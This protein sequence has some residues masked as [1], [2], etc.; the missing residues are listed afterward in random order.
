MQT[1]LA[2]RE[3]ITPNELYEALVNLYPAK[4]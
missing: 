3:N 1:I 2:D 4:A